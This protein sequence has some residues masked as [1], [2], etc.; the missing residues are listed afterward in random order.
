MASKLLRTGL[1]TAAL[2]AAPSYVAAQD[3][4]AAPAA[5]AAAAPAPA[6]TE[7]QQIQA[8]IGQIQQQAMQDPAIQASFAEINTALEAVDPEF[9]ALTERARTIR[10][11]ITAAQTAADNAKL[12]ALAAEVTQLNANLA[13]A[14]ARA[15]AHPDAQVKVVAFRTALV[16][17]MQEINPETQALVARLTEL[18]K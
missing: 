13:T 18:S 3:A 7:A 14:R 2:A 8:Q 6:L 1:I 12:H 11:D 15:T 4:A 16:K 9:K 5:P 17:K 10:A